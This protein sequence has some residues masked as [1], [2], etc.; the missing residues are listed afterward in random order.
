[1][2]TEVVLITESDREVIESV[3]DVTKGCTT[4]WKRR[5]NT[6]RGVIM[7]E[8]NLFPMNSARLL[9]LLNK[10]VAV[11][12]AVRTAFAVVTQNPVSLFLVIGGLFCF[13][14]FSLSCHISLVDC[15]LRHQLF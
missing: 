11:G 2:N 4:W 3:P 5:H 9:R 1:M 14:E 6:I 13:R 7:K 15:Q 12:V 10:L 8:I